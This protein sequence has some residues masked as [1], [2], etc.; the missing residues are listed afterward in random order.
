MSD[1]IFFGTELNGKGRVYIGTVSGVVMKR[2]SDRFELIEKLGFGHYESFNSTWSSNFTS[3]YDEIVQPL[4]IFFK[5]KRRVRTGEIAQLVPPSMY[6]IGNKHH[7]LPSGLILDF[8][9][10]P[11]EFH[12]MDALVQW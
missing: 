2:L 12:S 4:S 7:E 9:V 5:L 11:V 6:T 3:T 8:D 1:Q 10:Q